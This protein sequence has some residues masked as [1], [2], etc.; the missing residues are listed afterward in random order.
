MA[1]IKEDKNMSICTDCGDNGKDVKKRGNG[2]GLNFC[3]YCVESRRIEKR[4]EKEVE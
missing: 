2:E 3:D 1:T 4:K